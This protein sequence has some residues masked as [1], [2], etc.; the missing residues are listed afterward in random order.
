MCPRK[1]T[2]ESHYCMLI[3]IF[4]SILMGVGLLATEIVGNTQT[5][6]YSEPIKMEVSDIPAEPIEAARPVATME[7][8]HQ[9]QDDTI[10]PYADN[11]IMVEQMLGNRPLAAYS[12]YIAEICYNTGMDWYWFC[13]IAIVESGGGTH[14]FMPY[15]AWGYGNY[16]WSS[17]EEAIPSFCQMF[18]AGYGS[19]LNQGSHLAYCPGGAYY[20]YV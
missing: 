10:P 3:M 9:S 13:T 14:C 8:V 17:W 1:R 19:G 12:E 2:S 20:E 11:V 18:V 15:N 16:G 6:A 5:P 7:I 4:G